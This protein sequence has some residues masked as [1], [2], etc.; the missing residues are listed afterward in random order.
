MCRLSVQGKEEPHRERACA[1]QLL[2]GGNLPAAMSARVG[3]S[4]ELSTQLDS[5]TLLKFEGRGVV[6]AVVLDKLL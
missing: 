6:E 1:A 2:Y 3:S 4:Y 5:T